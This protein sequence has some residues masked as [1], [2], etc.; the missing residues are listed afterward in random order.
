MVDGDSIWVAT[1]DHKLVNY[2]G[3]AAGELQAIAVD[4]L[5]GHL[6]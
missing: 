5:R 1:R 6:V 3:R 2:V 4:D